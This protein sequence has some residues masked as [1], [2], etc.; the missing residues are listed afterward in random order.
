MKK[1]FLNR[2]QHIYLYK[3]FPENLVP[4]KVLKKSTKQTQRT[5]QPKKAVGLSPLLKK[6]AGGIHQKKVALKFAPSLKIDVLE[7][8]SLVSTPCSLTVWDNNVNRLSSSLKREKN[9][10]TKKT[11]PRLPREAFIPSGADQRSAIAFDTTNCRLDARH[12]ILSH[13]SKVIGNCTVGRAS[14]VASLREAQTRRG[15]G[16]QLLG[17]EGL[18]SNKSKPLSCLNLSSIGSKWRKGASLYS[19]FQ[20]EGSL[21]KQQEKRS[22]PFLSQLLERK[23]LRIL[24]G[25]LSNREINAVIKQAKINRG[26]LG[27]NIFRL[28]ESRLDVVLCKI[29]F[30]TTISFAR[31]WVYHG[32]IQVNSKVLTIANYNLQPGDIISI[33]PSHCQFLKTQIDTLL[34]RHMVERAASTIDHHN[35]SKTK[36]PEEQGTT[37][38]L[39]SLA[40][41]F[42][43]ARLG[44]E[45]NGS[46]PFNPLIRS[47][48]SSPAVENSTTRFKGHPFVLPW[49]TKKSLPRTPLNLA[50]IMGFSMIG[51][52]MIRA[53]HQ[54]F[55]LRGAKNTFPVVS[56]QN[57]VDNPPI[58]LHINPTS[59]SSL[60]I[61]QVD[62]RLS[63]DQREKLRFFLLKLTHV[64]VSFRLFTAVYLYS[65][66][67]I[68]LPAT[69]DIEK[70][71]KSQT[72]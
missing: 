39:R 5:N 50:N 66:Q 51:S 18:V 14:L 6:G 44:W 54:A 61:N 21:S 60:V 46:S 27:D 30:F 56:W 32:K 10:T 22:S 13:H 47:S 71:R 55:D 42:S 31:Q 72:V 19:C 43:K 16:K 38:N 67:R 59:G 25:N 68:L 11:S 36:T 26:G 37:K 62:H 52:D 4:W 48:T 1:Q 12:Q 40:I 57:L 70:I 41:S 49:P 29:G 9:G 28:L 64:E 2:V 23:K 45:N 7:R 34:G 58:D 53:N 33:S 20:L 69:I 65:P 24:Y 15:S 63:I 35:L 8:G 3:R 17:I